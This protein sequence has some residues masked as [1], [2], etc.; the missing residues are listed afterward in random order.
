MPSGPVLFYKATCPPCRSLSRLAVIVSL[1][2]IRRV[3]IGSDAGRALYARYPGHEGQL[4][5]LE[6][7]RVTFGRRVFAAVPRVIVTAPFRLLSRCRSVSRRPARW[8]GR[9]AG[10][11]PHT[12][13]HTHTHTHPAVPAGIRDT[14]AGPPH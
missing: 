4:I 9:R 12:H 6:T 3:P 8:P 13:T 1:G 11:H 10:T 5:L 7:R 2:V 14:D